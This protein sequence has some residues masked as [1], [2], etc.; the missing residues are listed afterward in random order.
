MTYLFTTVHFP[1]G[2]RMTGIW[3]NRA[4][5]A[6][7]GDEIASGH[8][9]RLPDDQHVEVESDFLTSHMPFWVAGFGGV[10][11]NGEPWL[12]VLQKAPME[13]AARLVGQ[14]DPA[15]PLRDSLDRA[16]R[17]NHGAAVM[18]ERLWSRPDLL[19]IYDDEGIDPDA[20]ADWPLSDLLLGLLTQCCYADLGAVVDGYRNGCAFPEEEHDCRADVFTDVFARWSSGRM[21]APSYPTDDEDDD[22]PDE[23]DWEITA[24]DLRSLSRSDLRAFAREVGVRTRRKSGKRRSKRRLVSLVLR[25]LNAPEG[26]P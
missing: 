6:P 17:F 12:F 9:I 3:N 8:F 2:S 21:P 11:P 13:S 5:D 25:S 18:G 26:Q 1:P 15:W 16:L 14:S 10:F 23:G 20:I 7:L 19:A 22:G 4:V 24:E